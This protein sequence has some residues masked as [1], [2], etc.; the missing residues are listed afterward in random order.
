MPRQHWKTAPDLLKN[1]ITAIFISGQY[2]GI[3][4]A[5]THGYDADEPT[6]AHTAALAELRATPGMG[7]RA[8]MYTSSYSTF[9][10]DEERASHLWNARR[11]WAANTSLEDDTR[12]ERD[13]IT[14]QRKALFDAEVEAR[15][16][17]ILSVEDEKKLEKA[18]AQ[19]RKEL[20]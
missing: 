9:L 3:L 2:P 10:A 17:K 14:A 4:A 16:K 20:G 15:A 5:F 18:R 12:A 13:R 1:H 6:M 11:A 19:A 7:A 8:G